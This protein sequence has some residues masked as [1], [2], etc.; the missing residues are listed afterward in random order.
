M[1]AAA[2][3]QSTSYSRRGRARHYVEM[4]TDARAQDEKNWNKRIFITTLL[5]LDGKPTDGLSID[6]PRLKNPQLFVAI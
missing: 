1:L 4:E 6:D 3:N 2:V 5:N